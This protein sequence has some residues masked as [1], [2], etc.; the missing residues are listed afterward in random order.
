MNTATSVAS[1]ARNGRRSGNTSANHGRSHR[2]YCG[3]STLFVSRNRISSG[4]TSDQRGNRG[5]AVAFTLH[6]THN[7]AAV[8]TIDSAF[9]TPGPVH[10]PW[11]HAPNQMLSY[12]GGRELL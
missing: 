1:N 7:P 5:S 11:Q 12:S 2:P 9:T 10:R 6:T 3:E 8:R 4:K